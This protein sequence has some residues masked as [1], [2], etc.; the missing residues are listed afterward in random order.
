M[1]GQTL[2][3]GIYY[4]GHYIYRDQIVSECIN[5]QIINNKL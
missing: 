2:N 5:R 4:G 1:S 3:N